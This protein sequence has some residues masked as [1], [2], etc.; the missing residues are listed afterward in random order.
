MLD[1][2]SKYG[3]RAKIEE[4]LKSYLR[5]QFVRYKKE[6]SSTKRIECEVPQG[7]VLGPLLFVLYI[8]DVVEIPKYNNILLYADDN[9]TFGKCEQSKHTIDLNLISS[10]LECNNLTPNNKKT[11]LLQLGPKIYQTKKIFGKWTN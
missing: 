8:N 4:L 10:W 1:K 5:K 7:S 3:L 11:Q 9:Y 2:C 6:S